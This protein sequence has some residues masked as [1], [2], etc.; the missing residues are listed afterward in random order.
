MS[1]KKNLLLTGLVCSLL[2]ACS[3]TDLNSPAVTTPADSGEQ[4]AVQPGTTPQGSVPSP[5]AST[6]G[7][8]RERGEAD[9]AGLSAGMSA[10]MDI[11][12]ATVQ[13]IDTGDDRVYRVTLRLDDSSTRTVVQNSQPAVQIG[14][15]VS[16]Q[17]G[18]LRS[19]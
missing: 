3:T 9:G 7:D 8:M 1:L 11:S 12:S 17:K 18:V 15:R 13:S 16:V 2:A 5:A 4:R 14:E 10:D 19:Y 6:P